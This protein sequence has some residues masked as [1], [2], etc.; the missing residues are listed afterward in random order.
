M[1]VGHGTRDE[2]GTQQFFELGNLLS[3]IMHP[4]PVQSCLL[5]FQEPTIPQGWAKLAES[6]VQQICVAPLLLFAAGHAKQDIP[7]L[8]KECQTQTPEIRFAQSRPIS[9]Q[10]HLVDLVC[11]RIGET[12]ENV[13]PAETTLLMVGR[14]SHDP[15]AQADMKVLTQVVSKRF[16]FRETR[17][18]FYAMAQPALPDV[19]DEIAE[20]GQSK[21]I[22]IQPHLLF[23]GRLYQ[24]I[25]RQ[26]QEAAE[27]H[28]NI[29]FLTTGYLGPEQAIAESIAARIAQTNHLEGMKA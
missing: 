1:L 28:Q 9:R 26:V 25:G 6:G 5:E 29:R 7:D 17:T 4:I 8:L 16:D 20:D 27:R 24:A 2:Q 3:K 11:R 15:C 21:T 22:L 10:K 19:L 13:D 14:G 18:A 12:A 23:H